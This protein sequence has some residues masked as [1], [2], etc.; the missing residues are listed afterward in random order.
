MGNVNVDIDGKTVQLY[1]E[2]AEC[3]EEYQKVD[4]RLYEDTLD[5]I[6]EMILPSKLA[7]INKQVGK[8]IEGYI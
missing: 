5:L 4:L 6:R 3:F 2:V 7:E 8:T 1:N